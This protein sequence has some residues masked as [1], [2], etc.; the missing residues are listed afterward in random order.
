LHYAIKEAQAD[1]ARQFIGA[2]VKI[3]PFQNAVLEGDLAEVSQIVE[4]GTDVDTRDKFG[5]TPT[6]WALS[7]GQKEIAEYLLSKGADITART[8]EGCTLLHQAS[9]A[10]LVDIARQLIAKG[11]DVNASTTEVGK[12]PLAD[13]AGCG[14]EDI[15][16]LLIA[17]GADVNATFNR[18][19]HALGDATQAGHENVVKLLLA[20]GAEVNLHSESRGGALHAA[21]RFGHA[22]ILDLL[23]ANGADVNLNAIRGTPLHRAAYGLAKSKDDKCAEMAKKLLAKGA[24][25]NV[26]DPQQGRTPLHVAVDRGRYKTAEVLIAA[27]ADVNAAD[28]EG[29]TL[30]ALAQG[31]ARMVELLRRHGAK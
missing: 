19:R 25:V 16:R 28:N 26:K 11:A 15:V 1:V 20:S 12:Q 4:G 6:Y 17:K 23:I 2:G 14:H 29:K 30:L 7:A 9:K 24:D 5:W 18:G 8:N 21:A 27:G 3:S 10:G 22:T 13:A 31:N